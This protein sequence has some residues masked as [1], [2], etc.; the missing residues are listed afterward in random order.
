M[1][2]SK[3]FHLDDLL[4]TVELLLR[5]LNDKVRKL[6]VPEDEQGPRPIPPRSGG[7]P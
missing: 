4:E 7:L 6:D 3:P 5:G 1:V 2:L